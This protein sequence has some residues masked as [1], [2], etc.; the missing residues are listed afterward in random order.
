[1]K[2]KRIWAAGFVACLLGLGGFLFLEVLPA[3]THVTIDKS[4]YDRIRVGM[5]E[6]EVEAIL[7]FPPGDYSNAVSYGTAGP[8]REGELPAQWWDYT[9]H[10]DGSLSYTDPKSGQRNP[11]KWWRGKEGWLLLFFGEDNRVI[12]RRYYHGFALTRLQWVGYKMGI[13]NP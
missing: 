3:R 4:V 8:E 11:G 6:K 12:E 10:P 9:E 2:R 7:P 5:T 13:W 1:M